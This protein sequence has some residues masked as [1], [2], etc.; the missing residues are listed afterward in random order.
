MF[1]KLLIITLAFVPMFVSAVCKN[2][3]RGGR[4]VCRNGVCRMVSR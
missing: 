3:Q 2:C 4:K 1:K